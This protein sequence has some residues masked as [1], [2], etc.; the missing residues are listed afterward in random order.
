MNLFEYDNNEGVELL[1]GVDEA[2]RGPLAGDVYAAAVILPKGY[3]LE[4]LNDSKK[5]TEK[6]REILYDEIIQNAVSYCIAAATIEE[7]EQLN[8]LNATFLAMR[9]AVEGLSVSP[10]LVLVDGNQN[11]HLSVHSRC[12]VKGD[13]TSA[14]IAA[15]SILAKVARDRYMQQIAKDYP[16]YQFEKH[17]GYG[18]KLHYQ[19]LDEYGVSQIHRPSF[20]KKYL[21]QKQNETQLKGVAGEQIASEHLMK[22]G[23]SILAKNF[24]APYGEVDMIA[25]KENIL[26]FVE[27]KTRNPMG[28]MTAKEAV[29]KS[30]QQ[31][32]VKT[33]GM[34]LAKNDL[35]KNQEL[36][37]RFDVI[38]VYLETETGSIININHI[39]NAFNGDGVN[40]FI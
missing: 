40:V 19:M 13:A 16:Q 33:A 26:V 5:L 14:C 35:M 38:E 9:R 23:Y 30:K 12:V 37:V 32:L 36:R 34:Y 28:M 24:H 6:K 17:K 31:K 25:Q 10:K 39:E 18:T 15:A 8:I 29:G 11:P 4:G 7:I 21:S 1:C 27:V 22:Q 2:G 20:L 3:I